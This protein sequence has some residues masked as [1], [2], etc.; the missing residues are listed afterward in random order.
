MLGGEIKRCQDYVAKITV[1]GS[2]EA[3]ES[4]WHLGKVG[5]PRTRAYTGER[6]ATPNLSILFHLAFANVRARDA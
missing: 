4:T 3:L 1:P 5:G 2:S 6:S